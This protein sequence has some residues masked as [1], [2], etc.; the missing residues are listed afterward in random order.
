MEINTLWK[1]NEVINDPNRKYAWPG[2]YP[3]FFICTDGEALSWDAAVE[4]AG[5]IR[6]AI[7]TNDRN[8]GWHVA[9]IE[10]NWEDTELYCA[11]TNNRIESAYAED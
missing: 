3:C 11:H 10:I 1:F 7:I 4:N 8:S 6:D 5:L 9:A 2:G